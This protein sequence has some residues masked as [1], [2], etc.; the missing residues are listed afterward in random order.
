KHDYLST[1]DQADDLL[2][3]F[4][5]INLEILTMKLKLMKLKKKTIR[6]SKTKIQKKMNS[7][8]TMMN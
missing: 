3:T 2:D 5:D 7:A 1:L 4:K 8:P 6:N